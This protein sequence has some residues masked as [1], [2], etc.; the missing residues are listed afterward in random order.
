MA[1]SPLSV[2]SSHSYC[3]NFT[4]KWPD[5]Y[6]D[7]AGNW[8]HHPRCPDCG[9]RRGC[10]VDGGALCDECHAAT[11]D[12]ALRATG[13]LDC[14]S[15]DC[16]NSYS[17]WTDYVAEPPVHM[18]RKCAACSDT[19]TCEDAWCP[20]ALCAMCCTARRFECDACAVAFPPG[21]GCGYHKRDK[22]EGPWCGPTRTRARCVTCAGSET[23]RPC[24]HCER[25]LTTRHL[26][27]SPTA[28]MCRRCSDQ[29][30]VGA[31]M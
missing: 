2:C 22:S 24:V 6:K 21:N 31:A 7:D 10:Q 30:L 25:V 4:S 14:G 20:D 28:S 13:T 1:H 26:A 18:H 15:F 19:L 12:A 9:A 5:K 3:D 23:H 8:A 16:P 29:V 11:F 27:R 17:L